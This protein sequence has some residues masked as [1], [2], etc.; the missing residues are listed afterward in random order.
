MFVRLSRCCPV[1]CRCCIVKCRCCPVGYWCPSS[2]LML[3][4]WGPPLLPSVLASSSPL[5][6]P[7]CSS[8]FR[9]DTTREVDMGGGGQQRQSESQPNFNTHLTTRPLQPAGNHHSWNFTMSEWTRVQ[10][11]VSGGIEELSSTCEFPPS[12]PFATLLPHHHASLNANRSA[13]EGEHTTG[14]RR[15]PWQRGGASVPSPLQHGGWLSSAVTDDATNTSDACGKCGPLCGRTGSWLPCCPSCPVLTAPVACSMPSPQALA[16][17]H[18]IKSKSNT[19]HISVWLE[20][21]PD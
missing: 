4:G 5:P 1:A 17:P 6:P 21:G 12:A 10:L 7:L 14:S 8:L 18:C 19:D 15:R 16:P 9:T 3:M 2:V 11:E 13:R 20:A